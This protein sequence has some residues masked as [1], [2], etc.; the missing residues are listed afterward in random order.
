MVFDKGIEINYKLNKQKIIIMDSNTVISEKAN[1][2]L[3]KEK[4]GLA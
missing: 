2:L 1:A 3:R 4:S